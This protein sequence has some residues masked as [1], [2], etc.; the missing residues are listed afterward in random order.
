MDLPQ[1]KKDRSAGSRTTKL[2]GKIVNQTRSTTDLSAPISA[3][4]SKSAGILTVQAIDKNSPDC[5]PP[6]SSP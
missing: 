4:T 1:F 3:A 2:K 6:G 5:C